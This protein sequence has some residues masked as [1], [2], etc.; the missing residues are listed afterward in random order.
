M[1]MNI[2]EKIK[3]LRLEK[4]MTQ[5]E[6]AGDQVTRNMLSLIEKGKAVPSLQ[7]LN[8][9]ASRLNVTPS[10]LLADEKEE[11][12]ML[13]YSVISDIL[14]A[15]K[16]KNY[17]ICMDLCKR[18]GNDFFEKDFEIGLIMAESALEI[19][20]EEIYADR[21]RAAWQYLDDAVLYAS[22]TI[23]ATKHIESMAGIMFD[24]LGK[25]SPS[26]VSE[27]MEPDSVECCKAI[28]L[29]A[30][31]ELCRYIIALKDFDSDYTFSDEALER[32]V[33]AVK[34]MADG[35]Y[36]K[37]HSLLNDILK[38]NVRLPGVLMYHL[39]DDLESCCR[40]LGNAKNARMYSLEKMSQ[41][42]RIL[43]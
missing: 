34:F 24:Y 15:F 35:E 40:Q 33:E 22:K 16:N 21:I 28:E 11:K 3:N 1:N 36:D 14:L 5:T 23:Y 30:D 18:L 41:L 10:F 37:A 20:V 43:S 6:L 42:E 12:M 8:Y 38:L 39:F 9:I 29:C 31:N 17:K 13:K 27:N 25:L 26:L 7:T 2:G 19:A 4:M 32:H